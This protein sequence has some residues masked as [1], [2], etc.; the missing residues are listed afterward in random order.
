MKLLKFLKRDTRFPNE[1]T[2]ESLGPLEHQTMAVL[3]KLKEGNVSAVKAAL[4][5]PVA[6]TTVM[7]TLDR[8]YK[9]GLLN[10]RKD[11]RAFL[12]SPRFSPEELEIFVTENVIGK[13]LDTSTGQIEPILSCIVDAVSER[14]RLLLD[15]LERIVREK[16]LEI[17][18]EE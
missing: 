6:Y 10:R 4:R 5:E 1:P 8:L 9:K 17:E 12:Y 18:S 11:N 3:W 15:E 16:R 2:V 13:L 7:T 14:D